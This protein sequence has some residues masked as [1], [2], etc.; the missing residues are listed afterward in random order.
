MPAEIAGPGRSGRV[1]QAPVSQASSPLG[2]ERTHLSAITS[3]SFAGDGSSAVYLGAGP[4]PCG[5]RATPRRRRGTDS[6]VAASIIEQVTRSSRRSL[7][8]LF[9]GQTRI[10]IAQ[11][12]AARR[13]RAAYQSSEPRP[14]A[15]ARGAFSS[16]GVPW[17]A[18]GAL[19]QDNT[20]GGEVAQDGC[21]CR[22]RR[23]QRDKIWDSAAVLAA[24]STATERPLDNTEHRAK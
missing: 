5:E 11:S 18:C 19:R 9:D 15:R 22:R 21:L 23:C 13:R 12:L 14:P 1:R 16:S 24:V 20:C 6:E 17:S 10:I 7:P 3:R 8:S 2:R 4:C